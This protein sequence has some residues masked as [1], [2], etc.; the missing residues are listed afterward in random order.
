M[1]TNPGNGLWP[2]QN[3]V[4]TGADADFIVSETLRNIRQ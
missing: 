1:Y 2:D 3:Q 4:I